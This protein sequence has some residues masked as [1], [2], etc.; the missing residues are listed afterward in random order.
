LAQRIRVLLADPYWLVP[1]DG[2]LCIVRERALDQAALTTC[3][4]TAQALRHGVAMTTLTSTANV[5]SRLIVGV[6]PDGASRARIHT[7]HSVSTVAI[8]Q[9]IFVARDSLAAPPDR[10]DMR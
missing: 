1:A 10:I 4:P 9:T 6:A 2:Y 5:P 7:K 8:E 3:T